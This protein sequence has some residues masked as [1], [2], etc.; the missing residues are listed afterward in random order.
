MTLPDYWF[1][2]I[3]FLFTGY[4]VLE[5]FDFG[6]GMLMPILGRKRSHPDAEERRRVLLNTIGP[7]WDGNEVWLITAGAA[8]FAAFPVWYAEVFSGF[9]LVLLA[10]LVGLITRVCAIEWRGKINEPRWRGWADVGIGL[11]SWIPAFAWGLVFANIVHGVDLDERGGMTSEVWDLL[12]PFGLLGGIA[13]LGLFLLHGAIFVALKSDGD[14]RA[15]ARRLAFRMWLPVT[16]IG[17]AF[18]LWTQLE[19]GKP[20]T[21]AMVALAAAA[22]LAAGL[23]I[24]AGRELAA[25]L[26][27]SLAVIAVSVL[28]FGALF[29]NVLNATDPARSITI[30]AAASSHYTLVVMS[31]CTIVLLPLVMI[32]Q[33]WTY[34]VFR[35]RISVA[36]IP[37]SI[38]LSPRA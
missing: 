23:L 9:Y 11:G 27:T 2:A 1:L 24:R 38:G 12:N 32:Y 33:A 20:W 22:L 17:G 5:G 36:Q 4:F 15:D 18:A 34:W 21:W 31:W 7:V 37:P 30:E 13:T 19:H 26:S 28:L 35:T 10:I 29:P 6:V 16:V 8:M 3:G 14:V 25:F